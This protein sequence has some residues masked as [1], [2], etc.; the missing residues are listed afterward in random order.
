MATT[1]IVLARI[2]AVL[3]L[4]SLLLAAA[5]Y[6]NAGEPLWPYILIAA[7]WIAA[8]VLADITRKRRFLGHPRLS[9]VAVALMAVG[10]LAIS[11]LS[12]GLAARY[13]MTPEATRR[14][15]LEARISRHSVPSIGHVRNFASGPIGAP[16]IIFIHGTPGHAGVFALYLLDP[17]PGYE[18]IAV[19][20]P[21]FGGSSECGPVPSFEQQA[22]AIAPL[23]T[24][25]QGRWPILV[26]HSLGGPIAAGSPPTIQIASAGW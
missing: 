4:M 11:M 24:Q 15:H 6:S 12:V 7:I 8:F 18:C 5:L 22:A 1:L 20:R 25:Q 3:T 10:G 13:A 21:G 26:G 9:S 14:L 23:L 17:V 2:L 19:D 16:R